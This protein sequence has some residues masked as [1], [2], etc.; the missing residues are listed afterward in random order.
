MKTPILTNARAWLRIPRETEAEY[1]SFLTFRD[2]GR[3][4]E[5]EKIVLIFRSRGVPFR[6]SIAKRNH[7][8][9]RARTW[10][11]YIQQKRDDIV[12]NRVIKWERRRVDTQEKAY[13]IAEKLQE[14]AL[15]MLSTPLTEQVIEED[16]KVIVNKPGKWS[17]GTANDMTKTAMDIKFAVLSSVTLPDSEL[18]ESEKEAIIEGRVSNDEIN[19]EIAKD[20]PNGDQGLST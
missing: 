11:N 5:I 3:D 18:T 19:Q 6:S 12:R 9:E 2:L 17:F 1:E 4:R 10:D 15:E 7:W 16:G 20:F 14:K 13:Q 8:I